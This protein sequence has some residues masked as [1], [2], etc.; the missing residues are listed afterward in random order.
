MTKPTPNDDKSRIRA[1][2][3]SAEEANNTLF[4]QAQAVALGARALLVHP[5]VKKEQARDVGQCF[6]G[7][8]TDA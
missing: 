5:F 8:R 6:V 4:E 1:D 7:R 3:I 2:S